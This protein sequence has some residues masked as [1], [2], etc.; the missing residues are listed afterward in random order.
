MIGK[1]YTLNH[2][3]SFNAI[4]AFRTDIQALRAIAVLLVLAFHV[5]PS[6]LT[7]GYVGADI[8]FVISG[9][10]ITGHLLREVAS[11]GRVDLPAFYARRARRLLPSASLTLVL[12]GVAAYL[13]M[14][15]FTWKKVA[16]DMAAST[17]YVEN[18]ALVRRS[19]DYLSQGQTPSPLQH[20]WSLAVE[21]Q[22]Y[23]GWPL[24]VAGVAATRTRRAGAKSAPLFGA[25]LQCPLGRAF[26]LPMGML[27]GLSFVTSQYYAHANPAARYF[28]THNRLHELG[29]DGLL[30]V[31]AAARAPAGPHGNA[32]LGKPTARPASRWRRT[33]A[34]AAGLAALGASGCLYTAATPFPGTATLV[35]VLGAAAV[36]AAG[37]GSV[38]YESPAHALAPALAQPWLQY[39]GDISY[40]LY[41]AH[42]PVVVMYPFITGRAVDG[43]F[44]D[45]VTVL[46]R[47]WALAQACKRVMSIYH[48][49]P[50][51]TSPHPSNLKV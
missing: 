11:T 13:W 22:F 26:A 47:S 19:V 7:G 18:W 28:M 48:L 14:P 43:V 29:L 49:C 12:V 44:A 20:F 36:I 51:I 8:F 31:W 5:W 9:Y 16:A 2:N 4:S 17:L 1:K 27:C 25:A 40:S 46:V 38:E 10:L 37:E 39:V 21:E 30:G 15:A 34:A 23:V 41:L 50:Y 6:R 45:G 42:W 35:P 32:E 33:L 3:H 24:L